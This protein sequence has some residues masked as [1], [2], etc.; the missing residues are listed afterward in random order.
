MC[1]SRR[2]WS[3][4]VSSPIQ[5]LRAAAG[6]D[7]DNGIL[8]DEDARSS[9]PTVFAAGDCTNRPLVHYGYR[10]RL[11]SVHNALEQGKLAAAAMLRRPR[12]TE[13]LPWFWSDQ[14]DIKLQIAG[15]PMP[16]DD[17]VV[18]GD[19]D[20]HSFSILTIRD[21]LLTSANAIGAPRDFIAAKQ[22]IAARVPV[23]HG[24]LADAT[25]PLKDLQPSSD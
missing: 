2:S 8:V 15:L 22:L 6:I 23:R 5:S 16:E 18:R 10:G 14:F 21:G 20:S 9:A 19:P 24:D 11:E 3:A 7:V 4:L 12:P 17:V 13:D 25:I 1:L